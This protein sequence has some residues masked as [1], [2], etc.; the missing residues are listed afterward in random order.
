MTKQIHHLPVKGE[1]VRKNHRPK[2]E[3]FALAFQTFHEAQ[4][5]VKGM[6]SGP[7]LSCSYTF[8]VLPAA[9]VLHAIFRS[10]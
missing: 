1:Q 7:Q 3:Y 5:T 9:F 10:T 2:L 4:M 8:Y 6:V